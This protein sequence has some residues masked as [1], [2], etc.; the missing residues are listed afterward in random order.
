MYYSTPSFPV[1]HQLP[2]NSCPQNPQLRPFPASGVLVVLLEV[3]QALNLGR[4]QWR[5]KAMV[6][7][8]TRKDL[9]FF[10]LVTRPL[11]LNCGFTPKSASVPP[12]GVCSRFCQSTWPHHTKGIV[13]AIGERRLSRQ[14][15]ARVATGMHEL[16]RQQ[17]GQ[18]CYPSRGWW[19]CRGGNDNVAWAGSSWSPP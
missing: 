12:T 19:R 11:G 5:W 1:H 10:S 4:H 14:E 9:V 17:S 2:Q 7:K 6:H 8:S 15:E 13:M 3:L 16:F 18:V